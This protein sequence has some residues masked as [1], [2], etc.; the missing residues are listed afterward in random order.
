MT[1]LPIVT[2]GSRSYDDESAQLVADHDR[3]AVLELGLG[4]APGT[5]GRAAAQRVDL[6]LKLVT[7]LQGLAGP[8][9]P[10][11]GTRA[12]AFEV[13]DHWSAIR[14]VDLQQDEGVRTGELELLHRARKLDRV[15]LIEHRK[16]VM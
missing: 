12:C 6:H 1:A 11:Q 5:T 4:H 2:M 16:R 8:S 10:H 7:G 13:P 9:V 3:F 15:F 14:A